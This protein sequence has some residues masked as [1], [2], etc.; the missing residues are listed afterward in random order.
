MNIRELTS[1][2]LDKSATISLTYEEIRD[3]ASALYHLTDNNDEMMAKYGHVVRQFDVLFDLVKNGNIDIR[4]VENFK[5]SLRI[6][7][8][9]KEVEDK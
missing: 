7:K 8:M 6:E 1:N 2:K 5:E 3:V 4:T 9:L